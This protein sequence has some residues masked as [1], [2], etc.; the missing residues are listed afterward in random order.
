MRTDLIVD[1]S[2]YTSTNVNA[3]LL[4]EIYLTELC[5]TSLIQQLDDRSDTVAKIPGEHLRNVPLDLA[6]GYSS[7]GRNDLLV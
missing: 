2:L 3:S 4:D 6:A 5:R 7:A 1:Q